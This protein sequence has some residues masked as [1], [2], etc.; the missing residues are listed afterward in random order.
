[1]LVAL[2]ALVAY[3]HARRL[4]PALLAANPH[5][6]AGLERRHW[7]LVR[8]EPLLGIGV[9][10][11]VG[12][13]AAFPLPPQQLDAVASAGASLT[14]CDGC[15]LPAPAADELAVAEQA[16]SRA[17]AGPRADADACASRSP[18]RARCST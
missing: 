5:P 11:A 10:A 8:S 1:V 15:P 7:R 12:V 4:R 3:A 16:G 18:A 2:I 14:S 9:A 6:P 17:H 13:L